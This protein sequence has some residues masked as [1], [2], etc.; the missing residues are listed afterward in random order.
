MGGVVLCTVSCGVV[1]E[2]GVGWEGVDAYAIRVVLYPHGVFERV[3]CELAGDGGQDVGGGDVSEAGAQAERVF[4]VGGDQR[5]VDCLAGEDDRA[6][7][8]HGGRFVVW[9]VFGSCLVAG[10]VWC[11]RVV[12]DG[13]NGL[14]LDFGV[15]VEHVS[16]VCGCRSLG[17]AFGG[18]EQACSG[19]LKCGRASHAVQTRGSLLT[20]QLAICL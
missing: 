16:P 5:G 20:L 19:T 18:R 17:G 12:E 6:V 13:R 7:G 11:C 1:G 10:R 14:R 8:R 3:G 2:G 15:W 4:W 9:E